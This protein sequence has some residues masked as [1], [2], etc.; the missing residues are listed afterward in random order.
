[1]TYSAR[2]MTYHVAFQ[3]LVLCGHGGSVKTVGVNPVDNGE[4]RKQLSPV[5]ISP[6]RDMS[7]LSETPRK[8]VTQHM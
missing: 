5:H 4:W 6:I 8:V 2:I 7:Y 3:L 1:M